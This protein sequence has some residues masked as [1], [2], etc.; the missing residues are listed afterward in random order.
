MKN[1]NK[2][3][4]YQN[5]E[6]TPKPKQVKAKAKKGIEKVKCNIMPNMEFIF[7][8]ERSRITVGQPYKVQHVSIFEDYDGLSCEI[9]FF[10]DRGFPDYV[11][12]L[13]KI[14]FIDVK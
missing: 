3:K 4:T 1:F 9:G 6:A 12:D 8:T 5:K 10:N 13:K 7:S 2:G 11:Y 14:D